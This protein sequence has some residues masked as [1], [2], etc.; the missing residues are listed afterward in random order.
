MTM[1]KTF[2]K[3]LDAEHEIRNEN[4]TLVQLRIKKYKLA[5]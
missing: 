3:K 1:I 5:S 4:G 2:S